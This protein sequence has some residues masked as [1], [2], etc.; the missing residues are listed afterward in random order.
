MTHQIHTLERLRRSGRSHL[1]S[2]HHVLSKATG[3]ARSDVVPVSAAYLVHVGLEC[4]LKARLLYRGGCASAED[5]KRKLPKVYDAY[6]R[7]SRG[8]KLDTLAQDLNLPRLMQTEGKPWVEDEC[9]TRLG[10]TQRPYSLRYGSE[11]VDATS[12][13]QELQR[14]DEITEAVLAGTRSVP[15]SGA[16]RRRR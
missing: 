16:Q 15:L 14:A 12:V 13:A 10:D 11:D 5:L 3:R 1:A 2:A 9:W 6:F 8:H 7:G 4:V